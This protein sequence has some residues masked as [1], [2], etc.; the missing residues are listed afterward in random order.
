MRRF[1]NLSISS[2]NLKLN[3]QLLLDFIDEIFLTVSGCSGLCSSLLFGQSFANIIVSCD[4]CP[5][6]STQELYLWLWLVKFQSLIT[7][8]MF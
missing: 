3:K 4:I 2:V 8:V 1:I 6:S 7:R 5:S